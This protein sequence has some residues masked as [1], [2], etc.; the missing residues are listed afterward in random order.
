MMPAAS[1][2]ATS[3][4]PAAGIAGAAARLLP[5]LVWG[6][7]PV[8]VVVFSLSGGSGI[9]YAGDFHLSFWP[10]GQR[11]LHGAS[12]YLEPDAPEVAKAI[13]FVY[14]AVGAL[15]LA[16][17]AALPRELGD[18]V[19]TLL[20]L[21]A[22]LLTLRALDV[23]DWRVYGATLLCLPVLSGWLV[24]NVTLLLGL[25]IAL[26]WR[27]RD[28]PLAAGALAA[29]IVS[30]KVFLWPL[31]I[32]L[33]A[34]RRYAAFAWMTACGLAMNLVAW[35]ILGFDEIG[36]YRALLRSLADHRDDLGYSLISIAL[37]EGVTRG[38][39]YGVAAVLAAAV[40]AACVVA[41]RRGRQHG[42]LA[43][44]LAICL[45]LT[46]IVQV[47]YYAL[48]LVPLAIAA[49]RIALVW[50][51]PLAF[52]LC[53][54]SSVAQACVGF[55]LASAIVVWCVRAEPLAGERVAEVPA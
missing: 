49:P 37:R 4:G 42:A 22:V 3:G 2:R 48:L 32:W 40:A 6:L 15:L 1:A 33:L 19:F 17:F 24:G 23:R 7:L 51:L 18:A 47:H 55:M 14:P 13:A 45:L 50:V 16:P 25:G 54:D 38:A 28:R 8:V 52:W 44:A 34:T 39:A 41:G 9:H 46:P 29:A 26:M 20:N 36:R 5:I 53:V 10:A 11:V 27:Y 31:A 43:I 35:S 12:P 21:A 30:F